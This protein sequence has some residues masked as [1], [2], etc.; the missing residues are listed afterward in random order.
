MWEWDESSR[1]M[2]VVSNLCLKGKINVKLS[3]C[4]TKYHAMNTYWG[5]GGISPPILNLNTRWKLVIKFTFQLSYH[6]WQSPEYTF[7]RRLGGLQILSGCGGEKKDFCPY[8][9]TNFSRPAHSLAPIL[10][11]LLR[12]SIYDLIFLI[13]EQDGTQYFSI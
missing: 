3:L 10:T 12:I 11:E 2:T 6:R 7:V 9:E 1:H 8:L 4:L 13:P 5:S